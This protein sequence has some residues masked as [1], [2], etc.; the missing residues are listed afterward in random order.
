MG[1]FHRLLLGAWGRITSLRG[2]EEGPAL[3]DRFVTLELKLP[4]PAQRGQT[5]GQRT[6]GKMNLNF[7]TAF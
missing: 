4:Q 5:H 1:H 3:L 6:E 7:V 2:T